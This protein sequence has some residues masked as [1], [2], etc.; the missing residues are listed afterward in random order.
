MSNQSIYYSKEHQWIA[1]REDKYYL[2]ISDFAQKQLNDIVYIDLPE[3]GRTFK[4]GD[5]I[6]TVESVKTASE[7]Y[8]P[9]DLEILFI[10]EN[11]NSMPELLNESPEENAWIATINILQLEQLSLLM[12][13]KKYKIFINT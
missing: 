4:K 12:D 3:V 9:V 13:A 5:T 6:T 8:A 11:L 2:G 1:K 7:I 10:N